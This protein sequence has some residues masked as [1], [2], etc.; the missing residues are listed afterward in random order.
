M[1]IVRTIWQNKWTQTLVSDRSEIIYERTLDFK[2][3]MCFD[4][5]YLEKSAR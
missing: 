5:N 2:V 4:V 1:S 3:T